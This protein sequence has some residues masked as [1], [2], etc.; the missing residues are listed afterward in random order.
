[1]DIFLPFTFYKR[2]YQV[3]QPYVIRTYGGKNSE[4]HTLLTCGS[5]LNAGG[6]TDTQDLPC[7]P[8]HF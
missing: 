2:S 5:Q 3:Y 8:S 1:M 6:K 4:F 7:P